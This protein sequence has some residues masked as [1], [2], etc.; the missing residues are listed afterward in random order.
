MG[1]SAMGA[2]TLRTKFKKAGYNIEVVNCAIE[3]I[4]ADAQIVITHES[5]TARAR[6][7]APNAEHISVKDFLNNAAFEILSSRLEPSSD[8]E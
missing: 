1:S 3:D 8:T 2:T 6:K 5:L 7:V 4:P